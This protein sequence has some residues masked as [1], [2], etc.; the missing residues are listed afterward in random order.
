MLLSTTQCL[1]QVNVW[2]HAQVT[3]LR[4]GFDSRLKPFDS[5]LKLRLKTFDIS[6]VPGGC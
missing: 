4:D 5:R 6:Y 1:Q 3:I 2:H